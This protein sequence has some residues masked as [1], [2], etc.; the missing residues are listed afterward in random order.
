MDVAREYPD[1]RFHVTD[2]IIFTSDRKMLASLVVAGIPFETENDNVLT[3]LFNSVKNFLIGLGKEGDLYLWTHL[4]K[5][6]ATINGEW[7]FD[8]DF[9]SRFSKKY[10]ALFTSSAFYKSTWYLT[11]GIP[12]DDVDTG[13]GVVK[14]K[15]LQNTDLNGGEL[16]A[17]NPTFHASIGWD[18]ITNTPGR[19][20]GIWN[21]VYLTHDNGVSVSD[22]LVTSTLNLPDTLA[23]MT[24]SVFL[25]N[26]DAVAKTVKLSGFIDKI[27]FEQEVSL[28]PNEK[29]EVAFAPAD[30]PQLKNQRMN[31]WWPN[32]Y[33]SPYLYDAGFK[34]SDKASGE[35]ISEVN[36]KAGIRQMSYVDLDT[37]TK[38]YINGKRLNPLGGNWGFSETNLNYR[39]REYDTAVRY[40]KEM[41]YNMIRDW[42]GQIGD[43]ELYEACDKYGIM[44]WQDFWLA[45]PWDGPDPDDDKMFLENSAD[46]ISRI[47]SHACIGIYCGR[48]EGFP[49]ASIDKV[50]REQVKDIHPQLGYIP[51]S[52]D[53]GVS[54][55]GPYQMKSPSFY[56]A[57][58]SHK[59][60]SERGM[61]NV[62]TFESLSR[63]MEPEHLWPQSDAWGQH[64][65]T[66]KGAQGGESFNNIMEKRYG[67][68]QSAEQ[69]T[70]LAQWLNYDGYRA[71]Y[72]SSQQDRL[73][74]LIW[75][76]HACWPSMVWCTYDYYFEPTAAYFGVKKACEPLHIQYNPVKKVAEV[77][78]FAGGA[79]NGLVAKAQVFDMY[80]KLI[81]EE[82]KEVNV[83][84]DQ[85]L[86]AV[87]VSEPDEEVYYIKLTLEQNNQVVSDNFYVMGK[88]ED[89]LL[90]LSKLPKADVAVSGKRF[91]QQG[92][93]WVGEVEIRNTGNVPALLVRLNLKGGDGEQILPVIYSDNYFSL[94]PNEC[95][96]I[97][98]SYRD[99]D[100]RG[101][102]PYVEITGFNK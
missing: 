76:S 26:A 58:Q 4:I 60:H 79:K 81:K 67:K 45:N 35:V 43:E 52:A 100:G 99:E 1:Y 19:E 7:N 9:L 18:W 56:F 30:Y 91:V 66:L 21:D 70:K 46:Y 14:Q 22:P 77:V 50:L 40:H 83:A 89:N 93:E 23:T 86:D 27:Q 71:M 90:A 3:N 97:K 44:I 54:G 73:G 16:G 15:N 11:F 38:I 13:I 87:S 69:F 32:G 51:S 39:G 72:E 92:E 12:Y 98:V 6:R 75:M 48:N 74:L 94:M 34:V 85:T 49:P 65:Y 5:K 80:G 84:E 78:N 20:I 62:P 25:K 24:P 28:Q 82:S 29:R 59:L 57:N 31:L 55:H 41:N 53:L 68:P 102:A 88:E 17:D 37:Q 96:T 61:P 47:R 36:Y 10:L 8:N 33:G 42:V 64:D 95:K 2:S 101:Q 63:M